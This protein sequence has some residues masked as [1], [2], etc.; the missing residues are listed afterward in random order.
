MK[1]L[2]TISMIIFLTSCAS[3]PD[4]PDVSRERVPHAGGEM[5]IYLGGEKLQNLA[6][7]RDVRE[8]ENEFLK[9]SSLTRSELTGQ[10][11]LIFESLESILNEPR[12][13]TLPKKAPDGT[14]P[15]CIDAY[16]EKAQWHIN[17]T[18]MIPTSFG[19]ITD[20]KLKP[21]EKSDYWIGN[22]ALCTW[23][24]SDNYFY[25][26]SFVEEGNNT[27]TLKSDP[28]SNTIDD[29]ASEI[30]NGFF[31]KLHAKGNGSVIYDEV[32]KNGVLI[33]PGETIYDELEKDCFDTF[34]VN[35]PTGDQSIDLADQVGYCMGRC[36]GR[37]LNTGR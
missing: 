12:I 17:E 8:L 22:I 29:L 9:R 11:R 2:L 28:F 10:S 31:Y 16:F 30:T 25:K 6:E 14:H 32:H 23:I 4:R 7:F 5:T 37:V 15:Q 33:D 18:G 13:D 3:K 34:Y 21:I 35:K 24:G 27:M 20:Y 19:K 36:D 1:R 26:I